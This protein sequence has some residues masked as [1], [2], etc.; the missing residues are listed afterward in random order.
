MKNIKIKT[1]VIT[2]V[3]V[4]IFSIPVFSKNILKNNSVLYT[5]PIENCVEYYDEEGK[6]H[7][8]YFDTNGKCI[9]D[10]EVIE[11]DIN[12]VS[13][14]M[15]DRMSRENTPLTDHI[16]D[17]NKES[18]LNMQRSAN[19][20]IYGRLLEKTVNTISWS[21]FRD[22]MFDMEYNA[23]KDLLLKL[24]PFIIKN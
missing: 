13:F 18:Y 9:A 24:E 17:G 23:L 3:L 7:F 11:C 22:V 2:A 12:G 10:I 5:M 8:Y 16:T 19:K 4:L 20:K 21:T 14:I 6:C 1:M 15:N